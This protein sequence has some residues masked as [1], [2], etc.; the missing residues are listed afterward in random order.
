MLHAAPEDS[1]SIGT[2]TRRKMKLEFKNDFKTCLVISVDN[3]HQIVRK[4]QQIRP[5]FK[6]IG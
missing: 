5:F 6:I 2:A 1:P 3:I 4:R